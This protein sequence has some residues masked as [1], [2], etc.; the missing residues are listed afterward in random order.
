[1]QSSSEVARIRQQIADEYRA[2]SRV[3][4]DFAEVSKHEYITARQENL[5]RCFENLTHHM[6]PDEAMKVFIQACERTIDYRRIRV[7]SVVAYQMRA[8]QLPT[9]PRKE[10][11]AKII[12]IRMNADQ[13]EGVAF[14]E[15][16]E[17]EYEGCT[18]HIFLSQ[19]VQIIEV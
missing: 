2:A 3:F 13:T 11:Y 7:G 1:M 16:I 6:T 17:P 10:W 5:S 4:C 9:H 19:I 12:D 15:G 18:E 8:D 14:V